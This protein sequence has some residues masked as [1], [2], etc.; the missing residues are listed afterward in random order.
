MQ[1][2]LETDALS[3]ATS[4][5]RSRPFSLP[6]PRLAEMT[7]A[8]VALHRDAT[9][10]ALDQSEFEFMPRTPPCHAKGPRTLAQ[11]R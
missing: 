8:A 11:G 2:K 5:N 4:G 9:T 10:T 7:F 1:G 6:G 3:D